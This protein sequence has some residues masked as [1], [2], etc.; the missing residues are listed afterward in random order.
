M[1]YRPMSEIHVSPIN[2]A[3]V[4]LV[5]G[6]KIEFVIYQDVIIYNV[7]RKGVVVS[8]FGTLQAAV[9]WCRD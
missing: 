8:K 5:N 4:L 1:G 7:Y 6:F 9:E 3:D 2:G